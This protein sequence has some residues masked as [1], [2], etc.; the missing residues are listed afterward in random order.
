MSKLICC[1]QTYYLEDSNQKTSHKYKKIKTLFSKTMYTLHLSSHFVANYILNAHSHKILLIVTKLLP[2]IFLKLFMQ[3][4]S[5]K[6]REFQ[7]KKEGFMK[8]SAKIKAKFKLDSENCRRK[9]EF[10]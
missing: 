9:V 2:N 3:M 1:L 8:G 5:E 10:S 7:R 6:D 4:Q